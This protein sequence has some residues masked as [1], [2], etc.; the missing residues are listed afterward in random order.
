MGFDHSTLMNSKQHEDGIRFCNNG[1][2]ED[3]S[4]CGPETYY[5]EN[6]RKDLEQQGLLGGTMTE[7]QLSGLCEMLHTGEITDEEFHE[8][9]GLP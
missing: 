8:A 2:H 4:D 9:L 5:C 7:E 3:I 1:C 6:C